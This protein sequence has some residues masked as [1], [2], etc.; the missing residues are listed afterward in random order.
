MLSLRGASSLE[1]RVTAFYPR[2][3]LPGFLVR[4][5]FFSLSGAWDWEVEPDRFAGQAHVVPPGFGRAQVHLGT[6]LRAVEVRRQAQVNG[7]YPTVGL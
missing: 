1:P 2:S 5:L 7:A 3:N 6:G 4:A